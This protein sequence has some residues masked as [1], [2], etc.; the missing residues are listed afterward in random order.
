MPPFFLSE[1]LGCQENLQATTRRLAA[2]TP[3]LGRCGSWL[4]MGAAGTVAGPGSSG[5]EKPE[6]GLV[7]SKVE[8]EEQ[9]LVYPSALE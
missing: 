7:D 5:R 9:G 6:A 3:G 1:A 4:W 2:D 8:R